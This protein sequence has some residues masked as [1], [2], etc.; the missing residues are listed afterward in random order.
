MTLATD[1]LKRL[2]IEFETA[3]HARATSSIDEARTLGVSAG[4]VAKV[5][6]LDTAKGHML[7]VVPASTRVDVHRVREIL[8]DP[9]VRLATEEEIQRDY[10]NYE[11]GAL[12]PLGSLLA[13]PMIIDD[14]LTSHATVVFADGIQ[15]ESVKMKTED[16]VRV[17][18]ASVATIAMQPG[19]FDRDWMQ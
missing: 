10:P 14:E 2:G 4:E 9:H 5:V 19:T 8:D 17:E 1:H 12:P 6:V 18:H 15:T 11:L 7:A 16:L 3:P 13:T